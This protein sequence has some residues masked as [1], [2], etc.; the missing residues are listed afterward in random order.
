[1]LSTVEIGHVVLEKKIFKFYQCIFAILLIS[2]LVKG[3]NPL[4]EQIQIPFTQRC[5][6]PSLVEIGP[7]VLE[8]KTKIR[9]VYNNDGDKNHGNDNDND[10]QIFY[11]KS[12][13]DHL[14]QVS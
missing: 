1:M 5:F 9:Q 11:K 13:L 8:K 2:P 6:V 4:F 3:C 7:V 14:A 10:G 12:S